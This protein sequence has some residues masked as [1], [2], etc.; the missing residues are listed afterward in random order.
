MKSRELARFYLKNGHYLQRFQFMLEK[1]ILSETHKKTRLT[2]ACIDL[3]EKGI[4]KS[5]AQYS[6]VMLDNKSQELYRLF[7]GELLCIDLSFAPDGNKLAALMCGGKK[8]LSRRS[9]KQVRTGERIF[10]WN[11]KAKERPAQIEITKAM[12]AIEWKDTCTIFGKPYRESERPEC[13]E[14]KYDDENQAIS[15]V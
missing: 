10:V 9:K 14:W 5:E 3:D 15:A 4:F 8:H 1:P 2:A 6:I 13:F 12:G 11:L 7:P